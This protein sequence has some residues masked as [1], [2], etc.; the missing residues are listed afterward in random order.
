M[1]I[2]HELRSPL[3]A[4]LGYAQ[5]LERDTSIS[6]QRR[7][8]IGI[9]RRSGEHLAGLIEG[10]L[11]ISKIEAAASKS[12]AIQSG[13]RSSWV[14]LSTCSVCRPRQRASSS[15]FDPPGPDSGRCLYG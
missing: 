12:I 7:D 3:N 14:N 13:S 8:D 4:I 15:S 10:L 1:G 6:A 9:I 2:S 5:L 11:D